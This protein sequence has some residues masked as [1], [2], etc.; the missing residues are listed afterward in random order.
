MT[1]GQG[2]A[3]LGRVGYCCKKITEDNHQKCELVNVCIIRWSFKFK[4]ENDEKLLILIQEFKICVFGYITTRLNS[5]FYSVQS[6]AKL[7]K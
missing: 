7:N 2:E 1:Q 6:S 4:R 5:Y 3:E